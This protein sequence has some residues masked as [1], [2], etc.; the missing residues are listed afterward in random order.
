MR[1]PVK[2]CFTTTDTKLVLPGVAGN[3]RT[4]HTYRS[5][6]HGTVFG[7]PGATELAEVAFVL[8][9]AAKVACDYVVFWNVA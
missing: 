8:Y 5:V 6:E 3:V 9:P 1:I 2:G 7:Y 4:D